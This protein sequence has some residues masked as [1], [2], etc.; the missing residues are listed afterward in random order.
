MS[1]QRGQNAKVLRSSCG[2]FGADHISEIGDV[3]FDVFDAHAMGPFR[4]LTVAALDAGGPE[5]EVKL[6]VGA[7]Q[8]PQV[9]SAQR[10]RVMVKA[11]PFEVRGPYARIELR[12]RA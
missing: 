12:E 2:L 9:G 5:R 4:E 1:V 3:D 7:N 10:R 11:D 8:V 6:A